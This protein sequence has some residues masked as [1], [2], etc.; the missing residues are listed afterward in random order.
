MLSDT[1]SHLVRDNYL[2]ARLRGKRS[3]LLGRQQLV[4]LSE[5]KSQTEIIGL[6]AE[7]PYGPE[8]SKLG[9]ESTTIE[10]ERA[11]RLGYAESV[12]SLIR[13]SGGDTREFLI[14][15]RRRS[16]AYAIGGLAVFKAQGRTWEEYL[17]TRQPLALMNEQ[18]LH[19]LY[20]LDDLSTIAREAGDRHLV[21]RVKG[22]S[23]TDIEGERASLVRD[24]INGWGE[25]R[26]YK[27]INGKLSGPDRENCLPI[28]GSEI[29]IANLT[30]I[31]RSKIIGASGIKDHLIPSHWKLN[32]R[33]IDQL[34]AATDAAQA[35][36]VAA[37]HEYYS[38]ILSGARQKYEESKSLSFIEVALRRYQLD[39]S[40]R[41]FLGFPYS[42]GIVLAFLTLKENEA[43][44]L[45]AV[46]AGV[47]AGLPADKLRS[48]LAVQE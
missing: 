5:S 38:R 31:V 1:I 26:F 11:V 27:Y 29:D 20:S 18:K 42:V 32:H 45:A 37:S 33:A 13:A 14:Q 23:M 12:M 10:T 28:A 16:D 25:E 9:G 30:I 21:D 40:R 46:L 3:H 36:D 6:L 41:V 4:A 8:L 39:L 47:A 48:L 22:F 15:Y 34:L 17:A 24:V 7:G 43:R 19:R 2:I 35:L 44:N